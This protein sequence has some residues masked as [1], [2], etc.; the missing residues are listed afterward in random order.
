MDFNPGANFGDKT[1]WFKVQLEKIDIS[2]DAFFTIDLLNC[3]KI[4]EN[5]YDFDL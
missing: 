5:S 4:F 1:F 3:Q 2:I